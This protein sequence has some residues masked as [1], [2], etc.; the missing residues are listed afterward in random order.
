MVG[1]FGKIK[2]FLGIEANT[3]DKTEPIV[4]LPAEFQGAISTNN[5]GYYDILR[6]EPKLQNQTEEVDVRGPELKH[7]GELEQ[8]KHYAELAKQNKLDSD[9]LNEDLE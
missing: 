1:L 5:K 2:I 9:A 4:S 3:E 7:V 8:L 6:S